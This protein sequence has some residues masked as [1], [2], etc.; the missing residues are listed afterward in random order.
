MTQNP[1]GTW[2]CLNCTRVTDNIKDWGGSKQ[3]S[4]C[5]ASFH[6]LLLKS[7]ENS[8]FINASLS[9]YLTSVPWVQRA[10]RIV[11][12]SS[13]FLILTV[14]RHCNALSYCCLNYWSTE[15]QCDQ[16][17]SLSFPQL[18]EGWGGGGVCRPRLFFFF[19]RDPEEWWEVSQ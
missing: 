13:H 12:H 9:S 1:W 17:T 15:V 18:W 16:L 4:S 14:T 2:E 19:H 6:K 8:S 11:L 7:S 3:A 5:R 10:A